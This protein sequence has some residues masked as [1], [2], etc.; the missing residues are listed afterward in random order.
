MRVLL[1]GATGA[2]GRELV[3]Q[4]I[5]AGHEVIGITRHA[6]ALAGSGAQEIVADVLDREGFLRALDGVSA[7]A[8]INQLTALAKPPVHYRDMR[9]TNRLR[10]E[11][12]STL[13]A[14]ARQVGAKRFVTASIFYGYGFSDRGRVLLDE[15]AS[16][17]SEPDKSPNDDVLRAVLSNEQQ[18]RAFGGVALRY[19]LFYSAHSRPSPVA[20]RW[21]GALPVVHIADAA[22]AA[23]LA[24]TKGKPGEAY[25]VA[26][27]EEVTYRELQDRLAAL[28]GVRRPTEVPDGLLRAVAPFGSQLV[29]RASVRLSSEKARRVLGWR[30]RYERLDD[31]LPPAPARAPHVRLPSGP[32]REEAAATRAAAVRIAD[33]RAAQA[34][35]AQA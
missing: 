13:I 8:V 5:A 3:P 32:T 17:G 15:S 20:R 2:I 35:E 23:V 34:R 25:N 16:F 27:D 26:T 11:G 33:A 4:L 30:P 14:A 1:A 12:T 7:D 6:G 29:T 28:E 24:L 9:Q 19:G 18:A 10:T 31:L 22:Q 21:D